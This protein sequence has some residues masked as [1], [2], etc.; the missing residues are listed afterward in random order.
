MSNL[1]HPRNPLE[2]KP[3]SKLEKTGDF[4]LKLPNAMW[5]NKTVRELKI[6][7]GIEGIEQETKSGKISFKT[8]QRGNVSSWTGDVI[9]SAWSLPVNY[10]SVLFV[11]SGAL[12]VTAVAGSIFLLGN[13][14]AA[15]LYGAGLALKKI[16]VN[17]D[18]DAKEYYKILDHALHPERKKGLNIQKEIKMRSDKIEGFNSEVTLLKNANL[19]LGNDDKFKSI[20][21]DND[22]KIKSLETKIENL[23]KEI[24]RLEPKLHHIE[25]K[26]RMNYVGKDGIEHEIEGKKLRSNKDIKAAEH[27]V[28]NAKKRAG[29]LEKFEIPTLEEFIT[30][31][32]D[33]AKSSKIERK[34][35]A[36]EYAQ[37]QLKNLT[38]IEIPKLEA[39][40]K[41]LQE[42]TAR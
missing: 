11:V 17:N 14:L 30:A 1:I 10:L 3:L 6:P 28:T 37:E 2:G 35:R 23:T 7:K 42:G 31:N 38:E 8:Q 13:I 29:K 27:A 4:L 32:K 9:D 26:G 36:L 16:A 40:L 39:D 18:P 5:K 41:K 24:K 19:T 12:A 21:K 22:T 25:N 15:P 20:L 33:S 34:E